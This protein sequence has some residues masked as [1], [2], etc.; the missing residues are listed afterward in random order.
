MVNFIK[1]LGLWAILLFSLVSAGELGKQQSLAWVAAKD[2][3]ERAHS[4]LH[5]SFRTP[6]DFDIPKEDIEEA[7]EHAHS[8]DAGS[9][10]TNQAKGSR[11]AIYAL[12]KIPHSSVL[13]RRWGLDR[14]PPRNAYLFWQIQ[15]RHEP[16]FLIAQ[17]WSVGG[18]SGPGEKLQNVVE[19]AARL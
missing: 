6:T 14:E 10:Y 8:Q 11:K 4:I 5:P 19:R 17:I 16:K 15:K 1:L 18:V 2:Y 7:W 9:L 12:T 13:G 3:L